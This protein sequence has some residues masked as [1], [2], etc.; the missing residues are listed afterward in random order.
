MLVEFWGL[1][2]RSFMSLKLVLP[3]TV[4]A[5]LSCDGHAW[6]GSG[7]MNV[8][9][10]MRFHP[11]EADVQSFPRTWRRKISRVISTLKGIPIGVMVL[12]TL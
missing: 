6:L 1:A 4:Y 11:A 7:N 9:A 5:V 12:T 10:L 2:L 8:G 3:D